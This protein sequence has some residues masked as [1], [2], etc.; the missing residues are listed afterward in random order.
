MAEFY[1]GT[2]K[3][4]IKGTMLPGF[5]RKIGH[6]Y[7]RIFHDP[8]GE[9]DAPSRE[10]DE[11]FGDLLREAATSWMALG[12]GRKNDELSSD[13]DIDEEEIDWFN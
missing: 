9:E 3:R 5:V 2:S 12:T 1:S 10:Y 6:R 11:G 8:E 13:E 4:Y 7:E